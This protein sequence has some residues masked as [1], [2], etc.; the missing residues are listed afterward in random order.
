MAFHKFSYNFKLLLRSI[1]INAFVHY[2]DMGNV[3]NA[4]WGDDLNWYFLKE[5]SK[6]P[7][8]LYN[9]LS[10]AFRLKLKNYLVIGSTIDMLCKENTEV[11]GAGLIY[12][13][14]ALSVQPKKVYAVRGPLT[15][16]ALLKQGIDCPEVYGDPALL[17]PLYYQ[18]NQE[19]KYKYGL[20]P[21]VSNLAIVS[22]ISLDGKPIRE[23]EDVLIIDLSKYEKWTDIIDQINSCENIISNSLHGLIVAEAYK[24]PNLW[25]EFGS[26]LIG[27]HFK[28]HDF[29]L[30]IGRDRPLPF[31][32]DPQNISE[33]DIRHELDTWMPGNINLKPLISSCP[34]EIK[35][36]DYCIN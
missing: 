13:D 4:N 17:L 7:I 5:I 8:A 23:R 32:I 15:R 28:F 22:N 11:W 26:A 25:V 12:G 18:S 2:D 27:G 14:Q 19:K 9:K 16:D 21:H 1:I 3:R 31:V 10:L 36:G 35:R 30:S 24:I 6:R 34:F 29:F 20:I 33:K